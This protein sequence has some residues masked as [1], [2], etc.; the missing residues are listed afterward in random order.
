MKIAAYC[1]VSTSHEN[2]ADSF[3]SQQRYFREYISN[4]PNWTLYRIYAD[5]GISGTSTKKRTAFN[6]MIADAKLGKFQLIITKEVSRFA[7]NTVDTLQFTRTLKRCGIGVIFMND[8]INTL[9]PDAELRLSIM[10]SIA[11]EESR[12]TSSRIKWGQTRR[13]EQGIVFGN[14]M[15]GYDVKNGQITIEPEGARLVRLIYHKCVHER[16]GTTV[17]ARELKEAG[18]KTYTG[19]SLWQGSVILRI[20][21]NEKYCGDLLQKKT[22]TPDYLTHEK[23]YN[24]GEEEQIY[25]RN[26]HEP[27]IDRKTWQKAQEELDRRAMEHGSGGHGNR[28][29]LSGKIKCGSCGK[30]FVSR[31]RRKK[32]GTCYGTWRCSTACMKGKS[33]SNETDYSSGCIITFQI[34]NDIAIDMVKQTFSALK[35]DTSFLVDQVTDLAVL[36]LERDGS[37]KTAELLKQ[38]IHTRLGAIASGENT[39]ESFYGKLTEQITVFPDHTVQVKLA[40]LPA[41]CNFTLPENKTC[42]PRLLQ[43]GASAPTSVS[44]A[45][46]SLKGME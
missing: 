27:I 16:K 12:K 14:S 20:L 9:D 36:M 45:T 38:E 33:Q 42:V 15:L 40:F 21:R 4:H 22:F 35:I 6:Q 7:R 1:R 18:Y 17:I 44:V 26:H 29:P 43:T 2:Q 31:N 23:K 41:L 32:D 30:S 25:I 39:P 37:C 34:R 24:H 3:E 10:G 8:G 13:M 46:A 11:Q 19:N 5:E 28:Y